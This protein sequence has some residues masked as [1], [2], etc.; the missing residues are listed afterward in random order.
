MSQDLSAGVLN[1]PAMISDELIRSNPHHNISDLNATTDTKEQEA[2]TAKMNLE[3]ST[4]QMLDNVPVSAPDPQE[5]NAPG[6]HSQSCLGLV[7]ES[8]VDNESK[9]IIDTATA[10]G[11]VIAENTTSGRTTTNV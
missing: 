9:L 2:T 1:H 3:S 11:A 7:E 6:I 10:G 8:A 5:L 4:T